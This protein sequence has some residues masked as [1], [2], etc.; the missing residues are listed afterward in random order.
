MNHNCEQAIMELTS[1]I[2]HAKEWGQQSVGVFLDLLKA[3]D[4]LNHTLLL[5]K[6]E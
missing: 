3:F 5:S 4:T 1:K 2:L 6:L